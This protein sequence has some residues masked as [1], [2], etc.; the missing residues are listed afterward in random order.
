LFTR[1]SLVTAALVL[2]ALTL[3]TNLQATA[4][5]G[6]NPPA[7]SLAR[8][9]PG[10]LPPKLPD[11][12]SLFGAYVSVSAEHGGS[13]ELEAQETFE[14][15]VGRTMAVDKEGNAWDEVFPSPYAYWSRD[16]GRIMSF[17]WDAVLYGGGVARWA[18][19]ADGDYDSDIDDR[20]QSIKAYGAPAFFVF[21]HEPEDQVGQAGTE[22][23]FVDAY[24]HV[25][26]RFR[27][28]G[29]TNLSYALVLMASTYRYGDPD[30][31]YPGDSYVDLV[32]ADG[33]NWHGCPG[34]DDDWIS[35]A[36]IFSDFRDFGVAKDKPLYVAEW[37][38][39]EDP[40]VPG[41]KAD[42][43]EDA[44]ATIRSWPEVKMLAYY[45]NEGDCPWWVDSSQRSLNAF[46]A[47]GAEAYFNPPGPDPG[48]SDVGAYISVTD[49]EFGSPVGH[50][51]QGKSI[52]WLFNGPSLHTVTENHG[53]GL[54]GSVPLPLGRAYS[55]SFRAAGN[56]SYRCLIHSRMTEVLRI[57]LIVR[58]DSGGVGTRF[59]VRWAAQSPPLGYT[60]DVKIQRPRSD[61][62]E[63]WKDGVSAT[64]GTFVPD[65]GRGTYLFHSRIRNILNG[66]ASWYSMDVA[67]EVR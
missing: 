13:S 24:R 30:A 46:K 6:L 17:G 8:M 27:S 23:D 12:G 20:A 18:D 66:A 52:E 28:K 39:M 53:M 57:P 31:F 21:H 4:L 65:A 14:S 38:S 33:Y 51:A 45:H 9:G 67:I 1:R 36:D 3:G 62:W 56:Y 54:F 29:V 61:E 48:P 19:I 26:D 16:Q 25:V 44:S 59:T 10:V 60:Y 35:F 37:G 40:D 34:R 58:P 7:G 43:I 5:A 63:T 2:G 22:A 41:R 32:G 50:P 49:F 42:W 55:F 64:S 15:M 47:M 11:T